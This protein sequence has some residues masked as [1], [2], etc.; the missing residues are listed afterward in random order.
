[1]VPL[2]DAYEAHEYQESTLRFKGG[3]LDD[4]YL[5]ISAPI[6]AT[7]QPFESIYRGSLNVLGEYPA[8]R[9]LRRLLSAS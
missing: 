4:P 1:M 5:T 7:H 2:P 3:G 9:R 8:L 6:R